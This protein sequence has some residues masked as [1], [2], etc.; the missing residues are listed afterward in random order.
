MRT[1]LGE[2]E[3]DVSQHPVYSKYG[4]KEWALHFIFQ[5]GGFDG[6]HHKQWV[7]DQVARILN[8]A[9]VIVREARWDDGQTNYRMSVGTS[10]EYDAWVKLYEDADEDG[11]PQ[12]EYDK[13]IAP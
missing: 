1:Y 8:N 2:T 5:Y 12:Y 3:V 7:L 4:P 6:G 10:D 13:G 9:P 11:E